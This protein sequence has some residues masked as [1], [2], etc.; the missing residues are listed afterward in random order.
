VRLVGDGR[1]PPLVHRLARLRLWPVRPGESGFLDR[2]GTQ[3]VLAAVPQLTAVFGLAGL[4]GVLPPVLI[5]A[6]VVE[7]LVVAAWTISLAGFVRRR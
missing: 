6:C 7:L 1:L 2:L 3:M 5:I 4:Y